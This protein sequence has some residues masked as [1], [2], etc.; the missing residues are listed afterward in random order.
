MSPPERKR[1]DGAER[2]AGHTRCVETQLL[3][4]S[5]EALGIAIKAEPL[6]GSLER[7]APGASH[8]MT[9]N[10]SESAS[11]CGRHVVGPSPT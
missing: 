9:V 8:A 7:P 3:Q 4:E 1:E 5:G 11:S 10:S 2:Q 6:G